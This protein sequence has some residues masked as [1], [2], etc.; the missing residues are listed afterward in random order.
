[1]KNVI[2]HPGIVT[3]LTDEG[4]EVTISVESACGTCHSRGACPASEMKEK[5]IFIRNPNVDVK[6]GESVNVSMRSSLGVLAVVLAYLLPVFFLLIVLFLFH[7][8]GFEDGITAIASLFVFVIYF[9]LIWIFRGKLGKTI[10][11]SIVKNSE[12]CIQ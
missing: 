6:P 2:T 10:K 12:K 5:K 11:F 9:T 8:I 7:G 1:M 3:K 4:A